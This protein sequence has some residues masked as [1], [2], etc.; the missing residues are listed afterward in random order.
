MKRLSSRFRPSTHSSHSLHSLYI[1]AAIAAVVLVMSNCRSRAP[2]A[3]NGPTGVSAT[4]PLVLLKDD[5]SSGWI[6]VRDSADRTGSII[7]WLGARSCIDAT[8]KI[9]SKLNT[10][11]YAADV[12]IEQDWSQGASQLQIDGVG[13]SSPVRAVEMDVKE[14]LCAAVREGASPVILPSSISSP[15]KSGVERVMASVVPDCSNIESTPEGWSCSLRTL[16][17][18]AAIIKIEDFQQSM[19]RR[20]SRQPYILARRAGITMSLARTAT[21]LAQDGSLHKFCKLLQF[22]LPEELP[23]IMTSSRWQKS[24]CDGTDRQRREAAFHGLAKAVDEIGMLQQLYENTSKVGMF[25][26]RI[27]NLIFPDMQALGVNP[28]V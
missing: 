6:P 13:M 28:C 22:S 10:G 18:Q 7:A 23:L 24:L 21:N 20:W 3:V 1:P 27:P 25:S 12:M 26:V 19:I 8:L 4:Q 15:F 11:I 5:A 16:M 14:A 17:P 2:D 9:R